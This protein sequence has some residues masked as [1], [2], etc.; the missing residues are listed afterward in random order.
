MTTSSVVTPQTPDGS[1]VERVIVTAPFVI[2]IALGVYV[3]IAL[4]ALSKVPVPA[5]D[6][7]EVVAV[8]PIV[9]EIPT[10]CPAQISWSTP[11][12][13]VGTSTNVNET[14][15]KLGSQGP[16]GSSVVRIKSTS[17]A[18]KSAALG[19]YVAFNKPGLSKVPEP[20]VVQVPEVA[21]PPI[22]PFKN[23]SSSEQTV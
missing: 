12:S 8:P 2:S 3:V 1:S 18:I 16:T 13:A 22:E 23:M 11:A 5:L 19:V 10:V 20:L 9:A 17:P 15:S 14:M 21:D 4:E 7:V 6:Q